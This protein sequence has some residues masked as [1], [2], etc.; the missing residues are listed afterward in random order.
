MLLSL[1]VLIRALV[2]PRVPHSLVPREIRYHALQVALVGNNGTANI[3]GI[4]I[5]LRKFDF[6][7]VNALLASLLLA[8]C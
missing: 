1:Y 6:F 2:L 8:N 4:N 5:A 7:S 3:D